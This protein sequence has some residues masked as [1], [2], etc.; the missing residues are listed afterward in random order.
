MVRN[1]ELDD[2]W[3]SVVVSCWYKKLVAEAWNSLE[4][5]R[6]GTS[7]VEAPSKQQL[8]RQ[9]SILTN[10]RCDFLFY[11]SSLW[12]REALFTGIIMSS[13]CIKLYNL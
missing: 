7:A 13:S 5:C 6:K 3:D 11:S 9:Q 1:D 2:C 8:V 4:S 10:F 12:G